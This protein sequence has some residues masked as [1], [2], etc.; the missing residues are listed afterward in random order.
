MK[1]AAAAL[2]ALLAL[3]A[4]A[5][6]RAA[7]KNPHIFVY[8]ND[9]LEMIVKTQRTK[10]PR[11]LRLLESVDIRPGMSIL[12]IGAGTGQQSRIMAERLKG[13]GHVYATD[14]DPRLVDYVNQQARELGL[15]NLDAALVKADGLDDFY[16]RHSYDLVMVYDV[17]AFIHDRPGFFGGLRKFLRPG[18]RVVVIS[19]P[20]SSVPFARE[21]FADM[22]GFLA[23]VEREPAGTPFGRALKAPVL[24]AKRNPPGTPKGD[25]AKAALF[26]LNTTLS[27][28][29]FTDF[30]DG[31]DFKKDVDFTPEEA[32]YA[33]WLL[34]R[35]KLAGIPK[36]RNLMEILSIEERDLVMLNK[37]LM[38]QRFRKYLKSDPPHPYLADTQESR[39]LQDNDFVAKT[40]AKAGYALERKIDF[41]PFQEIWIF[42]AAAPP[43]PPR[44]AP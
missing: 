5:D 13:T 20:E 16:G 8:W 27:T 41:S 17:F 35:L 36:E 31:E 7:V 44:S 23:E 29:F 22:S 30:T 1:R 34:R 40:F 25:P 39:W 18:G 14:I 3:S 24:A 15:K 10:I 32:P 38:I 19:D 43:A 42:T 9:Q 6:L 33:L 28:E 11:F 26:A 2:L 12:D 21:D 4:A 37:L